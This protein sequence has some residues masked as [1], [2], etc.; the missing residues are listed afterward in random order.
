MCNDCD[1]TYV[2]Q[3]D[4]QLKTIKINKGQTDNWYSDQCVIRFGK[5]LFYINKIKIN[6]NKNKN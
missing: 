5:V 6:T 3:T 4:R 1:A 2:G